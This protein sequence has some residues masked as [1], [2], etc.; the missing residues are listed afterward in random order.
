MSGMNDFF[1]V[2]CDQLNLNDEQSRRFEQG[3]R[4]Q[5]SGQQIYIRKADTTD[6]NREIRASF[7]GRNHA[8]LAKLY[9]LSER[10]IYDIVR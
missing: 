7:N 1:S 9:G 2:A 8:E 3:I 6:R 5:F 4:E 10:S